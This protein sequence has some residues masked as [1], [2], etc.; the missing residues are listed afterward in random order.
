MRTTTRKGAGLPT[1]VVVLVATVFILLLLV[2]GGVILNKSGS[3]GKGALEAVFSM[4]D[5]VP[6][7]SLGGGGGGQENNNNN[8][9]G[10]SCADADGYECVSD[11]EGDTVDKT[12]TDSSQ[13]CCSTS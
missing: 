12:C 6:G 9:G 1:P 5:L 13:V 10:Q 3:V 8:N 11:C 7:D 2:V 4:K